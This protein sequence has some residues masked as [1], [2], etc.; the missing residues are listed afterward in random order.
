[1]RLSQTKHEMLSEKQTKIK[2]TWGMAQ[3]IE[4]L[5][6]KCKALSSI[7]STTHNKRNI[8]KID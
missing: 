3:E 1:M 2:L 8:V 4:P 5:Q 7:S 6:G